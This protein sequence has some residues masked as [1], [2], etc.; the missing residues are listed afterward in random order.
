MWLAG[1]LQLP[2]ARKIANPNVHF[3]KEPLALIT[4][5]ACAFRLR[6]WQA[7]VAILL[8]RGAQNNRATVCR[9]N[10]LK[11]RCEESAYHSYRQNRNPDCQL[12]IHF[13]HC[14]APLGPG[15]FLLGPSV[16]SDFSNASLGP[17]SRHGSAACSPEN[18][19]QKRAG[20]TVFIHSRP[21]P[22]LAGVS[23]PKQKC[24]CITF[25]LG[26]GD[27]EARSVRVYSLRHGPL[28]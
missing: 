12:C 21:S 2:P 13:L 20:I 16:A 7:V 15:I 22:S 28:G 10:R 17:N 5:V 18:S 24:L 4:A 11:A 9:G 6:L 14:R 1:F 23:T 25:M 26:R 3:T 8:A 27:G 19:P